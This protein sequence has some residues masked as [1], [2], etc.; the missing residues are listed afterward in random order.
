MC[1]AHMSSI[2]ESGEILTSVYDINQQEWKKRKKGRARKV[3]FFYLF[4]TLTFGGWAL[5]FHVHRI[6]CPRLIVTLI[7]TSYYRPPFTTQCAQEKK[8]K[9]LFFYILI[10]DKKFFLPLLEKSQQ[11]QLINWVL[12]CHYNLMFKCLATINF[13]RAIKTNLIQSWNLLH[14]YWPWLHIMYRCS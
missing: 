11:I 4:T 3:F 7:L 14:F 9:L 1:M 6:F 8:N 10:L 12:I 5:L 2:D 13:D